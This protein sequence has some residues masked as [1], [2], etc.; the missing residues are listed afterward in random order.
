MEINKKCNF[1]SVYNLKYHLVLV[2]KY[3][4]KS[5]NNI[6]SRP[7]TIFIFLTLYTFTPFEKYY[8]KWELALPYID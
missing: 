4:K 8:L 5:I 6:F 3:R 1:H 7:I 2:T